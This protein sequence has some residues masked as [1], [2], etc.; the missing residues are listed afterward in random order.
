MTELNREEEGLNQMGGLW[1]FNLLPGLGNVLFTP[2]RCFKKGPMIIWLL[3]T[4]FFIP[5]FLKYLLLYFT[6][7]I[8]GT[9]ERLEDENTLAIENARES[10]GENLK[11]IRS[12]SN[13]NAGY[14]TGNFEKKLRMMDQKGLP[15]DV[16]FYDPVSKADEPVVQKVPEAKPVP[17]QAKAA[18]KQMDP[19]LLVDKP[20]ASWKPAEPITPG[21]SYGTDLLPTYS[22]T[23]L[24]IYAN[25]ALDTHA[26]TVLDTHAKTVLDTHA[27]TALDTHNTDLDTARDS[28]TAVPYKF[29][30]DLN[31][32]KQEGTLL[33]CPQCNEPRNHGFSFCPKCAK[34]FDF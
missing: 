33:D 21:Y 9:L 3:F 5:G 32:P 10:R 26:N 23:A 34:M 1:L 29:S 19:G 28:Y 22:N 12:M 2:K 6:L 17:A 31:K 14:S 18:K 25:T 8:A 13:K 30:A 16:E 4:L 11:P 15:I 24:D 20:G 27:N 7:S